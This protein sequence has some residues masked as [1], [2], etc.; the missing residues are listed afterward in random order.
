[1]EISEKGS[2]NFSRFS[3]IVCAPV[4]GPAK[5][6]FGRNPVPDSRPNSPPACFR[7]KRVIHLKKLLI[8]LVAALA[9]LWVANT[10]AFHAFPAGSKPRLIA[11][12]GMHQTYDK[13]GVERD[14]CTASRID[15]PRHGFLENTIASMKAA[16]ENGAEVVELDVHLTP[17][18]VFAVFHDWTLD[19]RTDGRGV[20]EET[21]MRALKTL[22]IGYGYTADGGRTFPFRGKG[23][24]LMPTL[25][26]VFDALPDG[27][28]LVN[29]KSRRREEGE[30]LA[31]LL[32]ANPAYRRQVV[33]VYGGGE[34]TEA[35][36]ALVEGL[37]GYSAASAKSCLLNYLATGWSGHVP[38]SCRD[39]LVPVP[40]NWSFLLWGWPERFHARMQAHGS[41]VIIMGDYA[42]GDAGTSGIDDAGDL[43]KVP[44]DFPGYLWTNEIDRMPALL[45][46]RMRQKP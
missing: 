7:C 13:A 36:M 11:H 40:A 30:A 32:N 15:A 20:T 39:R 24:G 35:A 4:E 10:S 27:R 26:E 22:D 43:A 9:A 25:T 2:R 12:R 1:M 17:D 31:A 6:P 44:R 46:A 42:A 3:G 45:E 16:F 29:F 19:C 33:A 38:A 18:K 21:P 37:P 8:L 5:E 28:F 23:I 34:P 41:E 14:T